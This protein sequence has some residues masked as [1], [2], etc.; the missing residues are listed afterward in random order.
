VDNFFIKDIMDSSNKV[1]SFLNQEEEK[2]QVYNEN[3]EEA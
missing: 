2:K 3:S 1:E